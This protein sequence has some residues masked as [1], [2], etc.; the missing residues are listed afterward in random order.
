M[1]RLVERILGLLRLIELILDEPGGEGDIGLSNGV[2]IR[3]A[4]AD[5]GLSAVLI[6]ADEEPARSGGDGEGDILILSIPP[7]AEGHAACRRIGLHGDRVLAVV[8]RADDEGSALPAAL[9]REIILLGDLGCVNIGARAGGL[10]HKHTAV[11]GDAAGGDGVKA[12]GIGIR[13][14]VRGAKIS[15]AAGDGEGAGIQHQP[16]GLS[17]QVVAQGDVLDRKRRILSI[18][19][20][21][22]AVV[23][24]QAAGDSYLRP[25]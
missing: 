20:D 6:P 17:R 4:G 2:L 13:I 18:H 10:L 3:F 1:L 25:V 14:S 11:D 7:A 16:I 22:G 12:N 5:G 8:R 9:N 19:F 23:D 21:R 15:H 24:R